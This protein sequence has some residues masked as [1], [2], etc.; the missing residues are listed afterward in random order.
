MLNKDLG[1]QSKNII[2]TQ[3]FHEPYFTGT[4]DEQMLQYE[5]FMSNQQ[6]VYN[7]LMS[8]SFIKNFS[9]G[10]SPIQPLEMAWKL[11]NGEDGF[12]RKNDDR[13]T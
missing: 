5:A 7:E 9:R 4:M 13:D 2:S 3:L 12:T 1:F 6:H 10:Q 11:E 8:A